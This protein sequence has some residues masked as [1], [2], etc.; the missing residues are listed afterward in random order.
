[1]RLSIITPLTASGNPYIQ[2][3]YDS[4]K[5]QT[6][7]AFEWV[8]VENHGGRLPKAIKKDPRVKCYREDE[9]EGIGAYKRLAC[10]LSTGDVI[11][12][13]DHDDMLSPV[14]LERIAKA[15]ADGA[16]F[17]FSDFC[18]FLDGSWQPNTPYRADCGWSTYPVEFQG[19]PLIA[20]RSPP[21]TPQN[22]RYVDF[23]PNHSRSWTRQAYLE[24][25]GHDPAFLVGDDH[26]LM[27]RMY[28]AGKRFVHIPE[29]LY[30]YR[31]HAQNNVKTQNA[32]IR[33]AT[34]RVYNRSIWALAE[35]FTDDGRLAKVDLCGGMDCPAGYTPYDLTLGHDLE[36]AW[37]IP[38]NSV[39]VLRAHDALEHLRDPV[40]A[41][42]E[43]FRVL[44]P[45]GFLMI[46]VPSSDGRG[47]VQDPTHKSYWNANSI[48][49][50]TDKNFARYIPEFKGRF[51]V[52]RTITW[53]PSDFHREHLISYVESHLVKLAAL[54]QHMGEVRW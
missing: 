45:G 32:A 34:E 22:L 43:C 11:V 42:N 7:Q 46:S 41:M 1:M 21:A 18:E 8:V 25:G 24:V 14:A 48:W 31:V 17:A 15:H 29:A 36:K 38:D 30:M 10:M 12:E 20:H 5:A 51:A 54:Y 28:L 53:H 3:A 37:P 27:V 4:L 35:K 52:S 13:F 9:R 40:M 39:G 19:H 47:S 50:Y 26:D 16:D 33:A 23:S 49:Y 2:A 44:A 6:V